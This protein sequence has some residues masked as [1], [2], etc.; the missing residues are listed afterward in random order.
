[1]YIHQTEDWPHF[2]WDKDVISTKL[3]NVNKAAG[4]L[5]G[6]LST[7]GFDAQM[8]AAVETLTHDIEIEKLRVKYCRNNTRRLCEEPAELKNF[9]SAIFLPSI[10]LTLW[11]VMAK[12]YFK[13]YIWLLETL[14]SL[15]PLTLA[16]IRQLWRRSSV[17]GLGSDLPERTFANHIESISEIFGIELI[18]SFGIRL[19][20]WSLQLYVVI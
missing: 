8:S 17:N 19:R 9:T 5:A 11:L 12:Y 3:A 16:Q 4:F 13:S 18:F 20:S 1:M 15:G 2:S 14:Q 6:R 10:S 7:I